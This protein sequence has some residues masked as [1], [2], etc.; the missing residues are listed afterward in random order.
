M[1]IR[2]IMLLSVLVF[3][4][5][6]VP[7][8]V[9]YVGSAGYM[10]E[11]VSKKVLIDA[12]FSDFVQQFQVPIASAVTEQNISGGLEPFNDIDL[13]L[14]THSHPGHFDPG[15]LAGAMRANPE[16]VLVSTATVRDLLASNMPDFAAIESRVVVPDLN[17]DYAVTTVTAAGIEIRVSRSPHWFRPGTPDEGYLFNFAF[18]LDGMEIV[19]ALALENYQK[20]TDIDVLF[21]AT[22]SSDLQPGHI[23]A[24]HQNGHANIASL[25]V[26]TSTMLE[27]TFMSATMQSVVLAKDDMGDVSELDVV[28][29]FMDYFK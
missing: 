26:Q 13:I 9:T 24:G 1:K 11:S 20:H 16:A 22:L 8:K 15:L 21:G 19:Y 3:T 7:T 17:V 29:L 23:V 25:A 18:D 12:P 5:A 14:I 27:V 6:C 10:L 2:M 4:A 28:Q